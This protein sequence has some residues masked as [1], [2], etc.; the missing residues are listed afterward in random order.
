MS[1]RSDINGLRAIAVI[2][3]LFYHF[4]IIG[5]GGG[6]VGVDI[7][8][9]I[10]G[11]LMTK[12]IVTKIETN[13]FSLKD[14]YIARGKRII[15]ALLGVV[16]AVL[17]LGYFY[18][19]PFDYKILGWHGMSAVGFFSNIVFSHRSDYFDVS[20]QVQWLLHTWSLAVEWQFYMVFP[21][22][23]IGLKKLKNGRFFKV[24]VIILF[25]FSLFMAVTL[26]HKLPTMSFF[27]LPTRGWEFLTGGLVF[28][29]PKKNRRF[30]YLFEIGLLFILLSVVSYSSQLDFPG[31][32]A[33]LPV[34]GTALII[35]ENRESKI[36]NNRLS[37][38][39][40]VISYSLYLW[41]WPVVVAMKYFD[42]EFNLLN[43]IT[44]L[45]LSIFLAH[46]S[47]IFIE[48]VFRQKLKAKKK[49][50]FEVISTIISASLIVWFIS[51]GVFKFD[52][53]PLRVSKSVR[54]AEV[55]DKDPSLNRHECISF[56]YKKESGIAKCVIGDKTIK[57]SVAILGDSHAQ[58][59]AYG[60]LQVLKEKNRSA[61]L[62]S[63]SSCPPVL[64]AVFPLKWKENR[65]GNVN[66]LTYDKISK[67]KN[68]K[69][70]FLISRWPLYLH[71][72]NEGGGRNIYI[73]FENKLSDL[74]KRIKDYSEAIV[75]TTCGLKAAGR[76]VYIIL[77][78][79]EM[80]KNT[81]EELAKSR[82]LYNRDIKV[83]IS[84][85][86]YNKRNKEVIAAFNK[87]KEKCGVTLLDVRPYMCND[88]ICSAIIN[89]ESLYR[90][91]DHLSLFGSALL[92]PLYK[93]IL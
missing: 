13:K 68:I 53:I 15:P 30:K 39:L 67:D 60:I 78:V 23:L 66:K 81:P 38:Y 91:S 7:F 33:I 10:S 59:G 73:S 75:K 14:F 88:K 27:T 37:Q 1:F 84:L 65:C 90:D 19:T 55:I 52:G 29:Y 57:P 76:N 43:V 36:L 4:G 17:I 12:I 77:P 48:Q 35:Y 70:I 41:H 44:A 3:V 31:Y 16:S 80:Y 63:Y 93:K 64:G 54:A 89:G 71:G 28:L 40:G 21:L 11:F 82:L 6:Y 62:Y 18:L 86:E 25:I 92:E 72:F 56:N 74:K 61:L 85:N 45:L 79:P 20:S 8:F 47:Y 51:Y 26:T 50:D 34:L 2:S 22:L 42:I 9:V 83:S 69:D 5:F 49:P 87:A 24:G 46:I 58:A 32:W